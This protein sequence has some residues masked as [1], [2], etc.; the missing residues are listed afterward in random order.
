MKK[1]KKKKQEKFS[2]KLHFYVSFLCTKPYYLYRSVTVL[3]GGKHKDGEVEKK[4]SCV[5]FQ[6]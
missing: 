6:R 1:E 5:T 4:R 3:F 2:S